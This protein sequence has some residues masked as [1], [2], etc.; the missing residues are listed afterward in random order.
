[1]EVKV[2]S[3]FQISQRIKFDSMKKKSLES[4][5]EIEGMTSLFS[6]YV[7]DSLLQIQQD[8]GIKGHIAEFGVF[9]GRVAKFLSTYLGT[10]EKLILVDYND[11]GVG[12]SLL[13]NNVKTSEWIVNSQSFY[14]KLIS[15]LSY[16]RVRFI[17]IDGSHEYKETK[18]E[19][20]TAKISLAKKGIISID[21]FENFHYPQVVAATYNH[22]LRPFS[23]LR[24]FLICDNKAYICHKKMFK[25]YGDFC[26]KVLP[27]NLSSLGFDIT[28]SKTDYNRKINLIS[29]I[30]NESER[31]GQVHVFGENLYGLFLEDFF[32]DFRTRSVHFLKRYIFL[33]SFYKLLKRF[34][35]LSKRKKSL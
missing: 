11:H 29:I 9:K 21:D 22:L 5:L 23:R 26:L 28:L 12:T 33:K 35:D 1:M 2:G 30:N 25:T 19:I 32:L 31:H 17:H 14:L 4:Y 7:I 24:L 27:F 10:K 6:L 13:K 16:K 15:L 3:G 8:M 18:S 34:L 20:S